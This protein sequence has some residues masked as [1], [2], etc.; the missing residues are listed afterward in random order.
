MSD[1]MQCLAQKRK[2][3][4]SCIPEH[5]SLVSLAGRAEEVRVRWIPC[6][7]VHIVVVASCV[8]SGTPRFELAGGRFSKS[9]Y[10]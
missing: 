4:T 8:L 5:D 3:L 6:D 9:H 7:V 10:C 1:Q 2:P